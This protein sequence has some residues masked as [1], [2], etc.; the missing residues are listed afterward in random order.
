MKKLLY[1]KAKSGKI[2]QWQAEV[3]GNE[4]IITYGY[5]G[6]KLQTT[7]V[8]AEP[9][10]VGKANETTAEEQAIKE[11]EALVKAQI[12][13]ELY[14]ETID[15]LEYLKMSPMLAKKYDESKVTFP[16]FI[17]PKL[18]GVR[19][20]VTRVGE[21][22]FKFLSRKH[23]EY[24]TLGHLI[25]SLKKL[26]DIG[27]T[28]DG[29]VYNHNMHFQQI[30]SA[31]KK[32]QPISKKLQYWVYD[33]VDPELS[34]QKRHEILHRKFGKNKL[35]F[36]IV[37]VQT[38][39]IGD[40]EEMKDSH[41]YY[42]QEGFEGAIIRD[43]AGPY[44]FY[45]SKY[46]MKYKEFHD[47]EFRIVG[48]EKGTGT[49]DGCIIFVCEGQREN[50]ETFTFKVTPKF[51]LADRKKMY[52][53]RE[54]YLGKMLTVQYQALSQDSIPIFPVGLSVRDYE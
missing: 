37:F 24:T 1:G 7:K 39:C 12:D 15:E 52:I 33:Y 47:A 38:D 45:R 50:S 5:V 44:E 9:K 42:V 2:K 28:F 31:V 30:V 48:S 19:C 11:F 20:L 3:K 36:G 14:R 22:E 23:K 18:D 34:Y 6:G 32:E 53:L 17:Q 25:P 41:D 13:K 27:E 35:F 46:L 49:H 4:V 8:I 29:E 43:P 26:M 16:C 54:T 51:S 40:H 21:D 10:N